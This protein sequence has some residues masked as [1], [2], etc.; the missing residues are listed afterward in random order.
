M[1]PYS[2]DTNER[3]NILLGLA[4]FSILFAW[5]LNK[6]LVYFQINLPWY[7]DS[8]SVMGF[9]ALLF[10]LFDRVCW[11][12]KILQK[13]KLIKTPNLSG[14]WE[15]NLSSSFNNYSKNIKAT[16][17]IFQTWTSIK[18]LL[19]TQDSSSYSESASILTN[20]PE[21]ILLTYQ[22]INNPK[23]NTTN[24]MHIHR[25][26]TRLLFNKTDELQGDYYSGRDRKNC[27]TLIFKNQNPCNQ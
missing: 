15:G 9:Y 27:G 21:G 10:G 23:V 8:P 5:I 20:N 2:L 1:H 17:K 18:I 19:F 13:I 11:N 24:S 12:F 6:V 3:K 7:L 16:L 26:T 25:G 14:V 4:I 22:Y